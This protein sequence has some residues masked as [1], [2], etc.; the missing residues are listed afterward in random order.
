[1][2]SGKNYIFFLIL[3]GQQKNILDFCPFNKCVCVVSA[4]AQVKFSLISKSRTYF[5]GVFLMLL[6]F[7]IGRSNKRNKNV[8]TLA[9]SCFFGQF[10][11][12][13]AMRRKLIIV[14]FPMQI[15][16]LT[17]SESSNRW[18]AH[19]E[20]KWPVKTIVYGMAPFPTVR[21]HALVSPAINYKLCK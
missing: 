13:V 1:M 18:W 17:I 8:S 21:L 2:D 11:V 10:V 12:V 14:T 4:L 15:V 9:Y 20:A 7:E 19:T 16:K 5:R 3:W 6:R